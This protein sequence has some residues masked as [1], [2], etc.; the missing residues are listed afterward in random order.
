MDQILL[1]TKLYP[2]VIRENLVHRARLVNQLQTGLSAEAGFGRKLTL[3]SAPAGYGKSTLA[4]EWLANAPA[5]AVWLSLDDSDNDPAR[6]MAYLLA[7]FQG[8]NAS[9]GVTAQ[10]MFRAPQPPPAELV[11]TALLNDLAAAE[12]LILVLDDY[13]AIHN[14][15]IHKLVATLL[16]RQPATLHLV[17]L[18]RED[19]LLPVSRLLARGQAH[20]LRQDD[21]R[22]ALS[23]TAEFLS[24]TMGLFLPPADLAEL[25]LRTEGWIAGLQLAAISI[26][27]HP[28]RQEFIA[29][30]A[31]SSR[32]IL[33][34][35]FE[36]VFE[37]QPAATQEFL[38]KTSLL[39]RLTG[40]LCDLVAGRNDSA[41]LLESLERANLFISPLDASRQWYRYHHLFQELL[42]HRLNF[43][44]KGE[45]DRLHQA[46]SQ[47]YEAHGY[48]ADAIGHALA[49]DDWGPSSRLIQQAAG[50]LL[51]R[52]EVATL[53]GWFQRFPIE[54]V[55]SDPGLCFTFG[56]P[57]IL[58]GQLELAEALLSIAEAA[59]RARSALPG[60]GA[61]CPIQ[62][63]AYAWRLAP[64]HRPVPPSAAIHSQNRPDRSQLVSA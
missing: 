19:P 42:R 24:R 47:W 35:L 45:V 50:D 17:I 37:R 54:L 49:A 59:A 9:L 36:E 38:L 55:Q 18:T 64:H 28:D 62:P 57:L 29:S 2:P 10:S 34:Y 22:F 25:Q 33:D 39:E 11:L 13:H 20:Q 15:L 58:S 53:L 26:Q 21:L 61:Y 23:E 8:V 41:S 46:A 60:G 31:G 30:F 6:F 14:Q 16:E 43:K 52:G 1:A 5:S 4:A 12:P 27:G 7:A 48:L 56:W 40:G 32:F 44:G 51:K 3:I 63:G